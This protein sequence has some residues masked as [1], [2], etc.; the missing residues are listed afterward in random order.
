MNAIIKAELV[1][2]RS[3][4]YLYRVETNICKYCHKECKNEHIL[5]CLSFEP[6]STCTI[7][8]EHEYSGTI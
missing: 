4:S 5:G 1:N 8:Y 2:K 6:P 7:K 3:E